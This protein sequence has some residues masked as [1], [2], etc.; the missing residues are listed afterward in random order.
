MIR[1]PALFFSLCGG[2]SLKQLSRKQLSRK[3]LSRKQFLRRRV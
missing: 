1:L 3:Q 2:I